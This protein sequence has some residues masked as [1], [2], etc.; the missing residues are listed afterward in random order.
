MI[1]I[2]I[3]A[4]SGIFELFYSV[5][6]L[7]CP[8]RRDSSQSCSPVLFNMRVITSEKAMEELPKGKRKRSLFAIDTTSDGKS[9]LSLAKRAAADV[10]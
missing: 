10:F 3:Y 9:R 4:I 1:Y 5:K 2:Y 7:H 6:V 8:E